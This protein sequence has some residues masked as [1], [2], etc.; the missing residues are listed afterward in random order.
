MLVDGGRAV[1]DEPAAG[2][3]ADFTELDPELAPHAA[4]EMPMAAAA[5]TREIWVTGCLMGER[6]G[7][8]RATD[9]VVTELRPS[10]AGGP[11]T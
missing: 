6:Y 4:S 2:V 7:T 1:V 8:P 10:V 9:A 5:A 11:T 3:V